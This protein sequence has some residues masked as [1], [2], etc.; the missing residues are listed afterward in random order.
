[1]TL[2]ETL[3]KYVSVYFFNMHKIINTAL[4]I[5]EILPVNFV[6]NLIKDMFNSDS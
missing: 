5:S 3:E 2:Y 1:M 6:N 4:R